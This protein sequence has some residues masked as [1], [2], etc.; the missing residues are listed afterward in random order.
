MAKTKSKERTKNPPEQKYERV[1]LSTQQA[2]AIDPYD[3]TALI[4]KSK[5]YYD[6]GNYKKAVKC[7]QKV[8]EID[9]SNVAALNIL[10]SGYYY[11]KEEKKAINYCKKWIAA[12]IQN[13]VVPLAL[14]A[15]IYEEKAKREAQAKIEERNKI[16]A[17]IS[18]SI[19]NLISTVIDPLEHLKQG[20]GKERI[21]IENALRGANLVR[22]IVNAM[23]LSF[24]GT[25]DDFYYDAEHNTGKESLD[26]K[27]IIMDSL[28]YSVSNMFDGKYFA[29]FMRK[30]FP[31]KPIYIEAKSKWG[32][33]SQTENFDS[34]FPFLKEYFF[35]I[36]LVL[37][38]AEKFV[39][40]NE[41]GSA[42]KLLILFQELILNAVKYSAFVPKEKR[43]LNIYFLS[44]PN[45]ISI[46][47]ENRFKSDVKT[48]TSGLGQVIIKN[49]AEL[50]NTTPRI[51]K[52]GDIYY[53]E[54]MFENFWEKKHE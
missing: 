3:I 48:K 6:H 15:T 7:A 54:L 34:I 52:D 42:I 26:V 36:N 40:G 9:H 50:I 38:D 33:I 22:G 24:K 17:D 2:Q 10:S 30:Y 32:E 20:A 25:I 51:N 46:K 49:S 19:K 4:K 18:H 28:K 53:V 39:I 8:L 23:N 41:K 44:N 16:I 14:L 35:E 43:L 13:P 47:V 1:S 11:Q 29:N 5:N 31:S 12:D 37:N 45:R 21:I 27:R